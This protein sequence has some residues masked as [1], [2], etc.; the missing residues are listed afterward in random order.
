MPTIVKHAICS[1]AYWTANQV[2][3]EAEYGVGNFYTQLST[4][5]A[6]EQRDLV[7][8]DE[9]AIAECYD[10]PN[11]AS[12]QGTYINGWTTSA[13]QNIIV[14]APLIKPEMNS[15]GRGTKG[16]IL[17]GRLRILEPFTQ[18]ER[19]NIINPNTSTAASSRGL[20]TNTGATNCIIESCYIQSNGAQAAF[21]RGLVRNTVFVFTGG[22]TSTDCVLAR[23][24]VDLINCTIAYGRYNFNGAGNTNNLI[25]TVLLYGA[26]SDA[27][28]GFSL[29]S[30]ISD[31]GASAPK[32][33]LLP[34]DIDDTDFIDQANLDF[35]PSATSRMID[36]GEDTTATVDLIGTTRE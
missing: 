35:R 9:V 19:I 5:E 29:S 12:Q 13:T 3:M 15:D 8:V 36:V 14:R 32:T 16:Y 1:S 4:W 34:I 28:S 2:E 25:N 24:D 17:A 23:A 10:D 27:I 21:V 33:G 26:T 30:C 18:V 22:S 31:T 11:L 7:A 6:V 20:Q